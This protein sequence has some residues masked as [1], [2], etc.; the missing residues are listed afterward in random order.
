VTDRTNVGEEVVVHMR[1][2]I[3]L[4]VIGL[5]FV[6]LMLLNVVALAITGETL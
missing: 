3:A 4:R 2:R 6:V 5:V 1:F